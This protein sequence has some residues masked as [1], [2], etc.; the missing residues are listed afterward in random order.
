MRAKIIDFCGTDGTGK[1][2]AY[3]YFCDQLEARGKRVLRTREVGS[4]HSL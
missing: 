3:D 4:P 1:T 2:T